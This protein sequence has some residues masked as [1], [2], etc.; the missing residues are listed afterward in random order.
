MAQITFP[1]GH[2]S[3]LVDL[4]VNVLSH[5]VESPGKIYMDTAHELLATIKDY[6]ADYG[7][8]PKVEDV[9]HHL[10]KALGEE[11]IKEFVQNLLLG[12]SQ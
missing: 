4:P 8:L 5:G 11:K 1:A 9:A 6:L 12:K 2:G 7:E 3:I 10:K